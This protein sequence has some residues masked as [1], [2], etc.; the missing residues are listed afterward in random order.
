MVRVRSSNAQSQ[1][2]QDF[3]SGDGVV[4]SAFRALAREEVANYIFVS[5]MN[6]AVSSIIFESDRSYFMT[7]TTAKR[8]QY[9]SKNVI[10]ATWMR[11]LMP[12]TSEL[13]VAWGLWKLLYL[14]LLLHRRPL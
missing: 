13:T 5:K 7:T 9:L 11:D 4:P 1:H 3:V 2:M 8:Q 10:L 14:F 6:G 12:D